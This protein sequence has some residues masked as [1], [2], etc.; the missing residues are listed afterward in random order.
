MSY[1]PVTMKELSFIG[2]VEIFW[3]CFNF[4]GFIVTTRGVN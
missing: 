4:V 2:D 3:R 1:T